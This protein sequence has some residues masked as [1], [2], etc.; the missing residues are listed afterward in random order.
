MRIKQII[1]TY[2]KTL[3]FTTTRQ[4]DRIATILQDK[5]CMTHLLSCFPF[6]SIVK[7]T[8]IVEKSAYTLS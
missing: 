4:M 1:G 5:M 3:L 8:L 6:F 7:K 2:N